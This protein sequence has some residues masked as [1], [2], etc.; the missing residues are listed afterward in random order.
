MDDESRRLVDD[1]E[2]LVLVRNPE[3]PLLGDERATSTGSTR[4]E[5]DMLPTIEPMALRSPNA[6]YEYRS[7]RH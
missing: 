2:V 3:L 4:L 7:V 6:V 5:L 1:E